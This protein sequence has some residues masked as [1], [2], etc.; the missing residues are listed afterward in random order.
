MLNSIMCQIMNQVLGTQEI[1][2]RP[3]PQIAQSTAQSH[4]FVC[5]FVSPTKYEVG[6]EN[7]SLVQTEKSKYTLAM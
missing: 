2:Q 3:H 6:R 4:L 5:L 1:S 7:I